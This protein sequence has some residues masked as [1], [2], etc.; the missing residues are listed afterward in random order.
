MA[1]TKKSVLAF[2]VAAIL[3]IL[4]VFPVM[5]QQ[6][7]VE[8][9]DDSGNMGKYSSIALDDSGHPHISY[10]DDD[11]D[12]LEYA[13]WNGSA[14]E[15]QTVDE[16]GNVG[17]Y[18]SLVID[19]SN[20][21]HI[22]YYDG[23][24]ADLKYAAWNG[25]AWNIETVDSPGNIGR[26]CSLAVDSYGYPHISYGTG[27]AG[28]KYAAWNGSAWNIEEAD[29]TRF[30]GA[31]TSI[32]L[33]IGDNPHIAYYDQTNRILKYIYWDGASW[34]IA[35]VDTTVGVNIG[36][37]ISIAM[38]DGDKPHISYYNRANENLGYAHDSNG[39]GDFLDD[40]EVIVVDEYGDP[41]FYCSIS[42]DSNGYPHISYGCDFDLKY[43]RWTGKTGSG[44]S[45]QTVHSSGRPGEYTSIALDDDDMPHISSYDSI[46]DSLKYARGIAPQWSVEAIE[47]ADDLGLYTSIAVDSMGQ[48]HISY[49]DN[50]NARLKYTHWTGSAWDTQTLDDTT[51]VG[52]SS[53]CIAVDASGYPHISYYDD[54]ADNL[55]YARWTGSAWVLLTVASDGDVGDFSS[56]TLDSNGYPH[57]SYYDSSISALKY[58]HDKNQDGDFSDSGERVFLDSEDIVGQYN[59]IAIDSNDN[60]HIS[61]Y[62]ATS[63]TLKYAWNIDSWLLETVDPTASNGKHSSIAL[64]SNDKPHISYYNESSTA[65]KYA[66]KTGVS[67]VTDTIDDSV[68]AGN[69]GSSIAIDFEDN[70]HISYHDANN[71]ALKYAHTN[72]PSWITETLDDSDYRYLGRYSSIDID[73]ENN[74]HISYYCN[75]MVDPWDEGLKYMRLENTQ[76]ET[77]DLSFSPSSLT[78]AASVGGANPDDQTLE[79]WN[80]GSGYLN[81]VVSVNASWLGRTAAFGQSTGEHD[82]LTISVDTSGLAGNIYNAGLTIHNNDSGENP[83]VLPVTLTVVD[84]P[85]L[86]ISEKHEEWSNLDTKMYNIVYTVKNQGSAT[87]TNSTTGIYIDSVL[88]LNRVCPSLAPGASTTL[89][90]L[91]PYTMSGDSDTIKICADNNAVIDEVNEGNNCLENTLIFPTASY[92]IT[93]AAGWNLVSLPLIPTITHITDIISDSRLASGDASN[94]SPVY[95]Y[96]TASAG[97]KYWG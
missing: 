38:D 3:V 83:T 79:I 5:A 51:N 96:D 7:S 84:K 6:W 70:V 75:Y 34:T 52:G 31:G 55:K 4:I 61:Y 16:T 33:D 36:D 60:P 57:F 37:S 23:T 94:L 29:D 77:P 78:F 53:T 11:D 41:G 14:W 87:A 24:N 89:I 74:P 59:C 18:S 9:V 91:G 17:Q 63:A 42:L 80:A 28:L 1:F 35:T 48:P 21:P 88:K 19:G 12:D 22:S 85:D 81:W 64:D 66:N 69:Y 13:S 32:A 47:R 10:Y 44:W 2:V 49:L 92:N 8:T 86:V 65:L 43:A 93:L 20:K 97:W 45:V 27:S 56:I 54:D 46:S 95:W 15:T 82:A 68:T 62:D 67:W 30:V 40:D 39:D 58:A 25:T 50:S 71:R 73:L 90:T 72:S 26:Y 76:Q